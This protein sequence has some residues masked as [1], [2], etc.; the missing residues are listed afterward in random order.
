[1]G[2][3]GGSSASEP[4]AIE[5]AGRARLPPSLF[6]VRMKRQRLSGAC[7][8]KRCSMSSYHRLGELPRKRHIVFRQPDGSLYHEHVMGSRGFS[9]PESLL[10][11][12]RPP[13]AIISSRLLHKC[14]WPLED[15]GMP[16]ADAALRH[17]QPAA[18]RERHAQPQPPALQRRRGDVLRAAD[19]DRHVFLSQRPRGRAG[20]RLRGDRRS[21]N[22]DGRPVV[23]G[24]RLRD[25][26]P[27]DHAPLADSAMGRRGCW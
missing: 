21:G 13:T 10:Y 27:R 12:R 16:L 7:P 6:C 8:P 25:H 22:D 14:E 26:S 11:H 24:G 15:D 23:P 1:M 3:T 18:A 9:G 5:R 19:D 17:A 2:G 4:C 20:L